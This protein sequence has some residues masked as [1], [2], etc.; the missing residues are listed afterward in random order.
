MRVAFDFPREIDIHRREVDQRIQ[1]RLSRERIQPVR[2]TK[3]PRVTFEEKRARQLRE[4]NYARAQAAGAGPLAP[5]FGIEPRA[6]EVQAVRVQKKQHCPPVRSKH[7]ELYRGGCSASSRAR[8]MSGRMLP[9]PR[10]SHAA[11]GLAE[12]AGVEAGGV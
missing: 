3:R 6:V 8:L 11:D 10:W 9:R 2:R 7:R 5:L 12:A 1:R 4:A